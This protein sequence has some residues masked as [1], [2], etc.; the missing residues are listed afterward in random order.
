M[1]KAGMKRMEKCGNKVSRG[2]TVG[3]VEIYAQCS[4]F[5]FP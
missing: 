5:K 2:G 1:K 3:D 4:K